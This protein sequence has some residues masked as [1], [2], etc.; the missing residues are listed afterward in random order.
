MT[1]ATATKETVTPKRATKRPDLR[2]V[3][4]DDIS[5]MEE[6]VV[7]E[8]KHLRPAITRESVAR[9]QMARQRAEYESARAALLEKQA[10]VHSMV[11][12]FDAAIA[13]EVADL[14]A[15]IALYSGLGGRQPQY[16]DD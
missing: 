9:E 3:P 5:R 11:E 15:T 16:S 6:Q 14:D 10:L 8:A 2:V 12:T 7:A 1:A 4:A 13:D